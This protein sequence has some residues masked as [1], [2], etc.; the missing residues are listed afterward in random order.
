MQW[1]LPPALKGL[2][3]EPSD[4][5]Q[6]GQ[7]TRRTTNS[8]SQGTSCISEN[9]GIVERDSGTVSQEECRSKRISSTSRINGFYCKASDVLGDIVSFDA[10]TT[11]SCLDDGHLSV[12]RSL[13]PSFSKNLFEFIFGT[14]DR[15]RATAGRD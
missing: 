8:T 7:G 12:D 5:G 6:S 14:K 3:C 4:I 10:A 11:S 13:W 9:T 15:R 2:L 1:Q